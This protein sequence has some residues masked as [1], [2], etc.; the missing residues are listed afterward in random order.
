MQA[1]YDLDLLMDATQMGVRATYF[2]E[3][4][5]KR[6]D[7]QQI[8]LEN[9]YGLFH[10]D[11]TPKPAATALH[12]LSSILADGGATATGF[13]TGGLD[14]SVSGLPAPGDSLV[15][16]KSNGAYDLVIWTEPKIWNAV[17][18]FQIS[19]PAAQAVTSLGAA[20]SQVTVFNPLLGT[21]P[22]AAASDASSV[23]ISVTDHPVVIEIGP[24]TAPTG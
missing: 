3:L 5:D 23:T 18:K 20:A 17:G 21:A 13:Q 4:L 10:A 16:Q 11:G 15:L 22:V 2:Y 8:Y 19:A 14:Y 12:N 7:P 1:R 6:D 24:A 9:H